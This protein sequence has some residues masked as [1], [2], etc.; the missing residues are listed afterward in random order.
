MGKKKKTYNKDSQI[1]GALRRAFVRSP[2]IS[3]ILQKNRKEVDRFN[4]DGSKSIKKAVLY[5]C[6]KCKQWFPKKFI[7]VD[8]IIPVIPV[9]G[10]FTTWDDFINR[11]FCDI[12]NLQCMCD[13]CHDE[14]TQEERKLRKSFIK[15]EN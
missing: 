15:K 5:Q 14:K 1:R 4:K 9:E 11:L 6:N 10:T 7:S 12:N 3:E 8:H 13:G 2:A